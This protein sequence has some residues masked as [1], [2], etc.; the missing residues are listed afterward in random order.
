M[1]ERE[2]KLANFIQS[3]PAEA[4]AILECAVNESPEMAA[5]KLNSF[6]F[7]FSADEMET[8]TDQVMKFVG[9][10]D[11]SDELDSDDLENVSGGAIPVFIAGYW[12]VCAGAG[13]LKSLWD[14]WTRRRR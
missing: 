14:N 3:H 11:A 7:D 2:T 9:E 1:T 13:A 8:M 4:K 6:G 5:D 12:I 10:I